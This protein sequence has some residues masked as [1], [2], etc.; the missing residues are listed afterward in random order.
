MQKYQKINSKRKNLKKRRKIHTTKS[1]VSYKNKNLN[2]KVR[3]M[4]SS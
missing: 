2:Y 3:E 1:L 4:P